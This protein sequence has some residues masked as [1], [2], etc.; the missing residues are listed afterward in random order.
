MDTDLSIL[1][2]SDIH[3]RGD[4]SKGCPDPAKLVASAQPHLLAEHVLVV[5]SGD[6]SF[7]GEE[8]QY[9]QATV[10]VQRIVERLTTE[11][12]VVSLAII[13]GNHDSSL[14]KVPT[15]ETTAAGIFSVEHPD[16]SILPML[17][18][19]H[20]EFFTFASSQSANLLSDWTNPQAATGFIK[21]GDKQIQITGIN[22]ALCTSR[23][24]N[25]PGKLLV[26]TQYLP[27]RDEKASLNIT[28]IHHPDYW[29]HD[30][31]KQNLTAHLSGESELVLCGHVHKQEDSSMSYRCGPSTIRLVAPALVDDKQEIRGFQVVNLEVDQR[32]CS[33]VQFAWDSQDFLHEGDS[34][35]SYTLADPESRK[36]ALRVRRTFH[37]EINALRAPLR[38]TTDKPLSHEGIFTYPDLIY[39][40]SGKKLDYSEPDRNVKGE[41]LAEKLLLDSEALLVSG[42]LAGATWL[43]RKLF[44]DFR[45]QGMAPLLVTIPNRK[46]DG[47]KVEALIRESIVHAYETAQPEDYLAHPIKDRVI[48]I[49]C[50]D[51][52]LNFEGSLDAVFTYARKHFAIICGAITNYSLISQPLK[53]ASESPLWAFSQIHLQ[54][55]GYF[56][57]GQLIQRW[58]DYYDGLTEHQKEQKAAWLEQRLSELLAIEMLAL[59]PW[60]LTLLL[61]SLDQGQDS[62]ES[63]GS[64]GYHIER[65]VLGALKQANS[66]RRSSGLAT[67]AEDISLEVLGRLCFGM[68]FDDRAEAS[69]SDYNQVCL[70]LQKA[71]DISFSKTLVKETLKEARLI[72][73]NSG[74]LL[75]CG[76]EQ[77]LQFSVAKYLQSWLNSASAT[78]DVYA[79]LDGFI[80]RLHE[81][82]CANVVIYFLFLTRDSRTVRL[83]EEHAASL[84][85]SDKPCLFG[86]EIERFGRISQRELPAPDRDTRSNR[87]SRNLEMDSEKFAGRVDASEA[88]SE[89]ALEELSKV[90]DAWACIDVLGQMLRS[91][92]SKLPGAE[93]LRIAR[94]CYDLGLR[95]ITAQIRIVEASRAQIK[96]YFLEIVKEHVSPQEIETFERFLTE[97]VNYYVLIIALSIV[98]RVARAVGSPYLRDFYQK[99]STPETERAVSLINRAIQLETLNEVDP[100]A[101]GKEYKHLLEGN[102][103]VAASILRFCTWQHIKLF[104]VSG[105]V[106]DSLAARLN[107]AKGPYL[108]GRGRVVKSLP[109]RTKKPR[110]RG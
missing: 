104:P 59:D 95:T 92:P 19:I 36:A 109:K 98:R 7:S 78:E 53:G 39:Y 40:K 47:K 26:D 76:S 18:A 38:H 66:A 24:F 1:H 63:A 55:F 108:T 41:L 6:V 70:D 17:G 9:D 15:H 90:R 54:P 97:A 46:L 94:G 65:L 72:E 21:L 10:F 2:I 20:G 45:Q 42:E 80:D 22:S 27:K 87:V 4:L 88:L 34:A 110:R 58:I 68:F 103:S 49:D 89:S 100:T 11:K 25:Y 60:R 52:A 74:A 105:Q 91:S 50:L 75:E 37:E 71:A 14:G 31:V 73:E 62:S 13:P 56:R 96:R 57:R 107:F 101:I 85:E 43:L 12:K 28:L 16:L 93:K 23:N 81:R 64:F 5:L 61:S 44:K 69:A 29:M 79:I 51:N 30:D 82:K 83:V 106:F 99:V 67:V 33:L 77:I 48:L 3:F 102:A 32:Q 86:E 35:R 84:F 8:V